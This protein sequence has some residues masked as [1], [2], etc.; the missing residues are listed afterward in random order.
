MLAKVHAAALIGLE[1]A[2]VED[3]ESGSARPLSVRPQTPGLGTGAAVRPTG[4]FVIPGLAVFFVAIDPLVS[5]GSGD[6]EPF[7]KFADGVVAQLKVIEESLSLFGH[8]DTSPGHGTPPRGGKC[9][10]R[11][12]N[13]CH[14]CCENIL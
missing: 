7:S 13:M 11:P 14:L 8:G 5:C 6:L 2:I 4:M 10:P 1:G 3:M 9:Q 12:D